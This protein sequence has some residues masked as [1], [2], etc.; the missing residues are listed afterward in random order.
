MSGKLVARAIFFDSRIAQSVHLRNSHFS[1]A[2]HGILI[3]KHLAIAQA[4]SAG[5]MFRFRMLTPGGLNL[6]TGRTEFRRCV[7]QRRWQNVRAVLSVVTRHAITST[8]IL[9]IC[10]I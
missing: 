8:G 1:D 10:E 2:I 5:A 4:G 7:F 9:K 6:S 3:I